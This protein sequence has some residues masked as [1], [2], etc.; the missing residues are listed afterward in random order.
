MYV[1]TTPFRFQPGTTSARYAS[2]VID[3]WTTEQR[4]EFVALVFELA[5]RQL[6]ANLMENVLPSDGRVDSA[7][8]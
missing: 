3:D 5:F 4:E 2:E 1:G 8:A 6:Q 7:A